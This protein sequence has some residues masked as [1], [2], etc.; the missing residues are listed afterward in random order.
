MEGRRGW[1][2]DG[3]LGWRALAVERLEGEITELAAHISAA[4]CRWLLLVG[5]FDRREGWLG[6]GCRS[7][8]R[9]LSYRCGLSPGAG[10]EHVRVAR[11]LAGLR[12]IRAAFGRG[13]L[14]YSQVR[15]LTRVATAETEAGLVMVA[16]HATAAQL[17]VIV[18]AYRGVVGRALGGGG[19]GR[20]LRCAH[21]ADGSLLIRARLPAEEGALVVAAL[22][23]GR[24]ALRAGG[25]PGAGGGETSAR[26]DCDA[27]P[28]A[29]GAPA[30]ATH[31][32]DDRPEVAA[33]G[34]GAPAEATHSGDDRPEAAAGGGGAAA[35][36]TDGG[37]GELAPG[38]RP[39][40][41]SADALVLMGQTLLAAG[42]GS[43]RPS[44]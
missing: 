35:E 29:A 39:A 30:E 19:G 6:W 2:M 37:D 7:C 33:G 36:A 1:P 5:E 21:D 10:R 26:D 4:T 38:E 43:V 23:A 18:A 13:E 11:R 32:G 42:P 14:C 16:R 41:S 22:E 3:R 28:T 12:A 17:D 9:W 8:A 34:G 40:V 25:A 44:V 31:S 15:A 27:G 20:Y 24:D